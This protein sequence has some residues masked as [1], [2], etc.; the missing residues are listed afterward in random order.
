MSEEL[1]KTIYVRKV[2]HQKDGS[3]VI[4]MGKLIPKSWKYVV[5]KPLLFSKEDNVLLLAI[6]KLDV[7]E[8]AEYA[9]AGEAEKPSEKD[10]QG[11]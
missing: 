9:S 4:A 5:L 8:G 7:A 6:H 11:A 10:S 3:T 1:E 2:R